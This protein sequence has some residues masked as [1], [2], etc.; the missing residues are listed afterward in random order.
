MEDASG[1]AVLAAGVLCFLT[2]V[3][4]KLVRNCDDEVSGV[5]DPPHQIAQ[6]QKTRVSLQ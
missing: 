4:D 5:R 1:I 3:I 6:Q 2:V